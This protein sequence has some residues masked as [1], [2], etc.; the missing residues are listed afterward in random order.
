[1]KKILLIIVML[2]SCAALAQAEEKIYRT[3]EVD[4]KPQ[5]ES[6]M[7]TFTMFISDNFKFPQLK[8]K[9][10]TIFTSFLIEKD[11]RMHEEQAFSAVAKD[12]LPI[13]GNVQQTEA[14]KAQEAEALEHMKREAARILALFDEKW[15]PAQIAG[16]PVRCLYH[17]P[18][19]FN[20][21]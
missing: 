1:M 18:I 14:E 21:E 4:V 13:E 8:N 17:Y 9:R 7:Y 20:L 5:L 15:I 2:Y 10:V 19:T 11:G 16:Q 3:P 12:Y 6:G